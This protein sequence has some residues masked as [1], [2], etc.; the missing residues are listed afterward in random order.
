MSKNDIILSRINKAIGRNG[1]N[2][3][4]IVGAGHNSVVKR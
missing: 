2:E 3:V 1:K 4:R